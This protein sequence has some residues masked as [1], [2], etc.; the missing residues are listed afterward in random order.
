MAVAL[1]GLRPVLQQQAAQRG[2]AA[3]REFHQRRLRRQGVRAAGLGLRRQQRGHQGE[4]RG[5][6]ARGA[7][8]RRLTQEVGVVHLGGVRSRH[9]LQ[10]MMKLEQCGVL[11]LFE[12]IA[13]PC[14]PYILPSLPFQD[15]GFTV[16]PR[17]IGSPDG[18]FWPTS[19]PTATKI[20][21]TRFPS[22]P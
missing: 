9:R 3:A 12:G 6:A 16:F 17:L 7:Q 1:R 20:S 5:Q 2:V 15:G 4:G 11:Y 22:S 21:T 8:Q 19:A 18:F 13:V 10:L 14:Q